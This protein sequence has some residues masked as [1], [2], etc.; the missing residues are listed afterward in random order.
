MSARDEILARVREALGD[1]VQES[2]PVGEHPQE[3]TI[4]GRAYRTAS[5]LDEDALVDLLVD[6]LVDYK[7]RV[8]VVPSDGLAE[9]I[10]SRL[11]GKRFVVPEGLP[12]AWLHPSLRERG[13]TDSREAPVDV[14][15]LDAAGRVTAK[16]AAKVSAHLGWEAHPKPGPTARLT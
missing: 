14:E 8:E 5:G 13:V 12:H 10:Q 9:A 15:R 7:A 6:R 2:R 3:V 16:A 4:G 1:S 11:E